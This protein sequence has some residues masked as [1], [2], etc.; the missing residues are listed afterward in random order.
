MIDPLDVAMERS[1]AEVVAL[2]QSAKQRAMQAVN[3]QLVELF[4]R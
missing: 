4:G 1:F 3:T 2:I